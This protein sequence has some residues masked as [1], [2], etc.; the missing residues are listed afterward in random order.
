VIYIIYHLI[1]FPQ[2]PS[3]IFINTIVNYYSIVVNTPLSPEWKTDIEKLRKYGIEVLEIDWSKYTGG[4]SF[5][6]TKLLIAGY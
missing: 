4:L 2:C 6:H 5:M 3:P 1:Q